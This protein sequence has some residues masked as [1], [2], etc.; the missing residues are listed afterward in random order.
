[1]IDKIGKRWRES[2]DKVR[3]YE[4]IKERR[5]ETGFIPSFILDT[6]Y[7]KAQSLKQRLLRKYNGKSLEEVIKGEELKTKK[8]TCYH[9]LDYYGVNLAKIDR[10]D[11]R[12]KV[13]SDLKLIYGIGEV[14]EQILKEEG[15]K[16][17]E[18][19]VEHPRFGNDAK[20]FLEVLD[21]CDISGVIDWISRWYPKSHPLVLY[22]SGF[23]DIEDFLFLDIE[24]MG[25]FLRPIILF[26]IARISGEKISITQY[27]VR[28]IQEEPPALV[29]TFS[30]LEGDVALVTFNGRTFDIPYMRERAVY[31][32]MKAD[33]E[34]LNVDL[35]YFARRAWKERV[36]NC[37]LSTIEKYLIGHERKD[38]VPSALVPEFYETY[39]RTKNPG[40]LIPII[41]HNK[42]DLVTL[43]NIFSK[44]WEEWR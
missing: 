11:L 26:G 34:K 44:L 35:L 18:D 4:V 3:E 9:L 17:I 40:P 1:M 24:T 14:T 20:K 41:E 36:P 19:L 38:D 12:K 29:A 15:Y 5:I 6:E 31:Y 43:A 13:I 32:R 2:V 37:R 33:F 39:L 23:H 8:G 16:T 22:A 25:L 28:D 21:R 27:L 7:Q 10:D 30:H 42:Q